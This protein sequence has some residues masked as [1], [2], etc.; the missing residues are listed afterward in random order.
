METRNLERKDYLGSRLTSEE[1]SSYD[2]RIGI[3]LGLALAGMQAAYFLIMKLIGLEMNLNFRFFNAVFY[4][5][6]LVIAFRTYNRQTG[7]KIKYFRGLKLGVQVSFI[8]AI[9]FAVFMGAYLSFDHEL[10]A[11]VQ[12]NI[13]YGPH[14]TPLLAAFGVFNEGFVG[15]IITAFVLLPFFKAS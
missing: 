12:K 5:I 11:Y 6:A 7:E 2:R 4:I 14:A 15:G 8:G 3:K 13:E 9:V 1:K 10:M